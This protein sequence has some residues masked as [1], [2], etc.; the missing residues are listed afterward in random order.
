MSKSIYPFKSSPEKTALIAVLKDPRDLKIAT[1]DHWY[2]IPVKKAPRSNFT[3]IAFYQPACFKPDGKRIEYYAEVTDCATGRRIDILPD[4]PEHPAATQ[5]YLKYTL[6][7]LTK[8]PVAILNTS[9]SRIS[10]G[11]ATLKRL[12]QAVNILGIFNV[13]PVENMMCAALKSSGISFFREHNIMRDRKVKYRLD[14]ALLCKNGKLDI[15][16]DSHRWHST[17][18]QHARDEIRDKWL[19]R[20]GWITLRFGEHEVLHNVEVCIGEINTAVESFGGIRVP[21]TGAL[22]AVNQSLCFSLPR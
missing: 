6:G 3:H 4:E 22:T 5:L 13:F 9:A 16:C 2:R 7:P 14:F 15:E 21:S 8:L 19:R 17:P 18:R 12:A 20:N 1:Q 10:F 11:Y